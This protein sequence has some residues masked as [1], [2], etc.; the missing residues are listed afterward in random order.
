MLLE[1]LLKSSKEIK[2]AADASKEEAK[3]AAEAAKEE[4]EAAEARKIKFVQFEDSLK[5][6]KS[7]E[8]LKMLNTQKQK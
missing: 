7:I 1:K 5:Y 4:K 8:L 3:A 2:T 6:W